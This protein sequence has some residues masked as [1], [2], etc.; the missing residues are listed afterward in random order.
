MKLHYQMIE[1]PDHLLVAVGGKWRLKPIL[2]LIDAIAD[3]S[4]RL[5]RD[6][7][8]VD[9]SDIYG[10]LPT[11]DRFAAGERIA[12]SCM[13]IRMVALCPAHYITHYGETVARNRGATFYITSERDDALRWLMSGLNLSLDHPSGDSASA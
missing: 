12:L 2:S 8:L 11:I 10:E 6:R 5:S 1:K 9:A 13:G 7:V 4:Q 3:E